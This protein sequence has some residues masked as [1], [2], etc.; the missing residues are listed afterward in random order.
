MALPGL[1]RK[2][3]L[4]VAFSKW[5]SVKIPSNFSRKAFTLVQTQVEQFFFH[6][7]IMHRKP[8]VSQNRAVLGSHIKLTHWSRMRK[9]TLSL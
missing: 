4:T 7:Q 3:S 2:H 6:S 1:R 9:R 5:T 8:T